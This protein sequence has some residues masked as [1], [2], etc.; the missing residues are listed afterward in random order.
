MVN[1]RKAGALLS[2]ADMFLGILLGMINVPIILKFVSM[3]DYGVYVLLGS[4]I[5]VMGILDF[6]FA[7]TMVRYYTKSITLHDE[8]KQENTLATGAIIYAG[9][10]V[11]TVIVGF[12]VYP[13]IQTIYKVSLTAAELDLAQKMFIIM[14]INF[15]L[16]I[17]TNVYN[18]AITAHERFTFTYA[19][20]IIKALLNP[21]MVYVLLYYTENIMMVVLVH[22][23]VNVIGVITK[24]YYSYFKLKV[25]I[26]LHYFDKELF[27]SIT[28]FAFFIFLNMIMDKIYWQTDNMILAAVASTSAV[29]VYGISSMLTRYYLNFSSNI[30]SMFLPKI[31]KISSQTDDMEELN[32]IFLK[33]GR[34]QYIIIM[35][36]LTGFIIFGKEFII[37]WVGTEFTN[38]Y[39]FAL[40]LMIPLIVPLIQ[41]TGIS[42]LQ[43]KN[44]HRFR[45]MIYFFIAILN[46]AASIPLAKLYGGFGC[47]AATAGSLILGQWIIINIYYKNKI[48]L[49]I[50]HFFKEIL[51][52]T[53]PMLLIGAVGYYINSFIVAESYFVLI[54]KILVYV[55][56]YFL[57][58][59]KFSCNGYERDTFMN[60]FSKILRRKSA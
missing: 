49:K 45:S 38:A 27:T 23:F 5:S 52:M 57:I 11:I 10:S 24:I 26:K 40:I 44:K 25:K 8:E 47:A 14:I 60:L 51:A 31:T 13:L 48:G 19:L 42:I 4:L 36:I 1:Q 21:I 54:P 28:A 43:A 46:F 6:G 56:L 2:Y 55:I 12:A 39:Y 22:T 7:G 34:I 37:L 18:A 3:G 15:V 41:N 35:L 59:G 16:S 50:G 33:I 17:S 20:N 29:A 32:G 30:A 9:I 58:I 53:L